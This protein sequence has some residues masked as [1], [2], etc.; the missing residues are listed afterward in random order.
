MI[1][2]FII[3]WLLCGFIFMAGI[4]P[5]DLSDYLICFVFGGLMV[6]YSIGRKLGK[7]FYGWMN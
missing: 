5:R 6:P 2:L 4:N 7:T 1:S 3:Y